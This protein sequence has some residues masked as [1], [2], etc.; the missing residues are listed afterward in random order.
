MINCKIFVA[1]F[2]F[3]RLSNFVSVQVSKEVYVLDEFADRNMWG[4]LTSLFLLL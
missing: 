1:Y 3:F 4:S 2:L